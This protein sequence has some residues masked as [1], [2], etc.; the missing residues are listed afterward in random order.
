MALPRITIIGLGPADA[1]FL[2]AEA[3]SALAES[4]PL[5]LRTTRHPAALPYAEGAH[6]LDHH[7]E[8]AATFPEVYRAMVEELVVA[9]TE[10]GEIR[11]AVPGSPM[12][13]ETAAEL[14]R[15]DPRVDVRI[16]AGL[17][18]LDLAWVRLGIDPVNAGVRLVDAERFATDAAGERG[19][20]LITQTWSQA[21]LSEVKLAYEEPPSVEV[22]LLHHLGLPDEVVLRVEFSEIDRAL[23]PD[24][25][26]CCYLP[27]T[28]ANVA[29]ELVRAEAIVRELRAS[30]PWDMEQT[31]ESLLR[32]LL[33]ETYEA[34]EAIE[35]L[36]EEPDAEAI[37]HLQ[38]ELG[39]VFCQVL[40]HSAIAAEEGWFNL[41]DVA[42]TLSDKLV[43][44]HP[45]VFADE[46][47]D[48]DADEVLSRW[49]SSKREEKGR[50]SL[51]DGIPPALPGLALVAKLQRRAKEAL[52][53]EV[54]TA[55]VASE[56]RALLER[57]LAGDADAGGALL[58]VLAR[59]VAAS[60]ADPEELVRRRAAA[61][62]D[63]FIEAERLAVRRA[64]SVAEELFDNPPPS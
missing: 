1:S 48:L 34:I 46:S 44:R 7:Y 35:A 58:F 9:A 33:E 61:F 22:V 56:M 30:C 40:F 51:L 60:G 8:H 63:A 11:Y 57:A 23:T 52:G 25:L 16:V 42:R 59:A 3:L 2:T 62:S 31:H 17:S 38:E 4:S 32:H 43:A 20:L 37:D 18:F 21:L 50:E 29:A 53:G 47:G 6:S 54:V 45:H 27:E 55:S 15:S 41:S 24:H 36:G 13:L 28:T 64:T 19:P 49:E 5:Y 10:Y 39:D 14:L 12:V 26:T